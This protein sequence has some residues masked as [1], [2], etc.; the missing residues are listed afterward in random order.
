M[1][2]QLCLLIGVPPQLAPSLSDPVD[3]EVAAGVVPGVVP[4]V[5]SEVV[6]VQE[7]ASNATAP[8]KQQRAALKKSISLPSYVLARP[9]TKMG[10]GSLL[11]K[12]GAGPAFRWALTLSEQIGYI[13]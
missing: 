10:I 11:S 4:E 6:V 13:C 9:R 8:I 12:A 2:R 1:S 5:F 3:T 7:A